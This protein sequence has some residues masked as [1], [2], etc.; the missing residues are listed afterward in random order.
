[1]MAEVQFELNGWEFTQPSVT[2]CITTPLLGLGW[3]T[4][5]DDVFKEK[6]FIRSFGDSEQRG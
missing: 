2:D 5:R 3:D 4:G 6:A 1:M